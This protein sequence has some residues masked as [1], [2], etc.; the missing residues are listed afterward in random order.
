MLTGLFFRKI[1]LSESTFFF[2]YPVLSVFAFHFTFRIQYFNDTKQLPRQWCCTAEARVYLT[3]VMM[4][5]IVNRNKNNQ[6]GIRIVSFD[7]DILKSWHEL[8]T[9]KIPAALLLFPMTDLFTFQHSLLFQVWVRA[10]SQ[11]FYSLGVGFGSLI[12][13]GSYNKFNN[14]CQ[15]W[16]YVWC[17]YQ[18]V[19]KG[20]L[21]HIFMPFL[22]NIQIVPKSLLPACLGYMFTGKAK[23]LAK[24]D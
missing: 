22:L 7:S 10:A 15:R 6:M 4:I 1:S 18:L 8:S 11:I 9:H 2:Y 12:T 5:A 20:Y 17:W 16:E 19:F 21:Y 3:L 13:F 14:N 24:L 23:A